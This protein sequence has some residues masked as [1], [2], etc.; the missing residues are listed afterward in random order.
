ML[1]RRC[2][3][4]PW[5]LAAAFSKSLCWAE[6]VLAQDL[7]QCFPIAQGKLL[8]KCVALIKGKKAG[9]CGHY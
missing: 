2:C 5:G 7:V 9:A 8:T 3:S 4:V 1:E 6:G